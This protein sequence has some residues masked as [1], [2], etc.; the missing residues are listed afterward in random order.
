MKEFRVAILTASDKGAAGER[1]DRSGPLLRARMEQLGCRVVWYKVLP[2]RREL[3]SREMA[4]LCDAGTADLILTTGGTGLSPR[5]WTPEATLDI[6]QRQVPGMAE[7]M[8]AS[9]MAITPRAMLSRGVAAIRGR[10]LI[11]NLPGSPKGAL[12]NL[13]AVLPALEHGLEI[14]T[15]RAHECA[16]EDN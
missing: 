11:L 6:A 1:E 5:D 14:L 13:E 15:D 8:R 7:A 4:G 9:S 2:D 16:R 3:L 12:E 10:T